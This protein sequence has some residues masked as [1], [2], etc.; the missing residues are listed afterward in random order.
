MRAAGA[1]AILFVMA[2]AAVAADNVCSIEGTIYNAATGEPL[3]KAVVTLRA[4][5]GGR[6]QARG[7]AAIS[8]AAGHYSITGVDPGAY[9]LFA[10]RTGFI[11][12]E[13]GAPR[14]G[15]SGTPILLAANE[16][17]KDADLRLTPQ[18][19]ITG[20]V[21]DEDG[22]PAA[23]A[24]V[25]LLR[26][27]YAQGRKQLMP[28]GR[29]VTANDQGEFR[30]FGLAPGRY[31]LMASYRP[32]STEE[33]A[34]SA[35]A[36]APTFYPSAI[37]ADSAAPV[38]VT[39]GSALRGIDIRLQKM[40]AVQIRGRVLDVATNE[41]VRG[42]IVMLSPR[43]GVIATPAAERVVRVR[44]GAFEMDGITPGSYVL[45]A[46]A[47]RE[48]QLSA[49]MLLEVG[50]SDVNDL[51]LALTPGAEI[52]G[53]IKMAGGTGELPRG[54]RVQLEPASESGYPIAPVKQD[55]SFRVQHV[56]ADTYSVRVYGLPDT[57]YVQEIRFADA[58]V[59]ESGLDFSR[60]FT[61]GELAITVA[62]T[63]AH[64]DGTVLDDKGQP[65]AGATVVIAA[66]KGKAQTVRTDQSGRF[67]AGGLAPGEY[68]LWAFDDIE[69]GAWDDPEYMKP[70]ETHAERIT[71]KDNDHPT[72][73]LKLLAGRE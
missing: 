63:A 70:H 49:R 11:R 52:A 58:A 34:L 59:G 8:D 23:L 44:G 9:R 1:A 50:Q 69:A 67:A 29:N 41:P 54:L 18:G 17:R 35:Q 64:V 12:Q 13:L 72:V 20:R 31:Y 26:T 4:A 16:N 30:V 60:G 39:A 42:A 33:A 21:V 10:E 73:Q 19:V 48:Q 61:P 32:L 71:V 37:S 51:T 47:N 57:A 22:D 5:S 40:S 43:A 62:L 36:Y 28:G 68:R 3:R 6:D 53:V 55:G 24:S 25:T 15:K 56:Q 65:F 66:D 14:P 2:A 27:G 7:R 46:H 45:S 38:E